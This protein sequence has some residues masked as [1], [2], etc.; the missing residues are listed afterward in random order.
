G[1]RPRSRR[2]PSSAMR[3]G[4]VVLLLTAVNAQAD[5]F[6]GKGLLRLANSGEPNQY[7]QFAGYVA[8]IQDMH[9]AGAGQG[10]VCIPRNMRLTQTMKSVEQF[11]SAK[12]ARLHEP[13]RVLVADALETVYPCTTVH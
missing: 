5:L 4:A 2:R 7:A 6:S 8:G 3:W 1:Q 12:P 9:L 11:L 13:A 10:M